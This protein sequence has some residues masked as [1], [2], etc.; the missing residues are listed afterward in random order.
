MSFDIIP[1]DPPS[2]IREND[3]KRN[4]VMLTYWANSSES[5]R[6]ESHGLLQHYSTTGWDLCVHGSGITTDGEVECLNPADLHRVGVQEGEQLRVSGSCWSITLF[7]APRLELDGCCC[8][9]FYISFSSFFFNH[10]YY[11]DSDTEAAYFAH[12][13]CAEEA[14]CS[15]QHIYT[16]YSAS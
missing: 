16:G 10:H 11:L 9:H 1:Q 8:I 15:L 13:L 14:D 6:T 4:S 12:P 7:A 2:S 5:E 3:D